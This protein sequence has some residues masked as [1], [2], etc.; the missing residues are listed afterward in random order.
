ML[1]R[2]LI[3]SS[4]LLL[5][6]LPTGAAGAPR[7]AAATIDEIPPPSLCSTAEW[8]GADISP[9]GAVVGFGWCNPVAGFSWIGGTTSDVQCCPRAIN[10]RGQ[11][12][13]S[14]GDAALRDGVE[15]ARPG[16][17][18]GIDEAG[19]VVG[20]TAGFPTAWFMDGT[21]V[22]LA[23]G[24]GQA[25]GIA[26]HG[27]FVAGQSGSSAA[28]WSPRLE[29]L[30]PL[31]QATDLEV[32]LAANDGG[33]AVGVSR[34]PDGYNHAVLWR[35]GSTAPIRL[36]PKGK[37]YMSSAYGIDNLGR[38]VGSGNSPRSRAFVW[39]PS[40]GHV[41]LNT[42]VSGWTLSTALAINDAGQITGAGT[43]PAGLPRAYRLTLPTGFQ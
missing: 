10:A 33:D 15:L 24:P 35:A 36:I 26:D 23:G 17:A 32:A 1:G 30:R 19:T 34:T 43:N 22:T 3:C 31:W 12:A 16:G 42:L 13:S 25:W 27:A 14:V 40:R 29:L 38:V 21:S 39:T 6:V 4:L 8:R 41:D 20:N 37:V 11:I 7:P 18:L 5:V 2:S 9:T 28:R